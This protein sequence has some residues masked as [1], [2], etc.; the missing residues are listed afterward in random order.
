MLYCPADKSFGII[1]IGKDSEFFKK[2]GTKLSY[3]F[4]SKMISTI[5]E[6]MKK[7]NK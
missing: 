7:I 3:V 6:K 2:L 1:K 5:C 4:F